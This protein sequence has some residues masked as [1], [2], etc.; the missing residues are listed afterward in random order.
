MA[1]RVTCPTLPKI[2]LATHDG[3]VNDPKIAVKSEM[4]DALKIISAQT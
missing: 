4:R 3:Q 1:S 2:R